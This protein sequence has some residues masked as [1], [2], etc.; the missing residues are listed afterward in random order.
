MKTLFKKMDEM[1]VGRNKVTYNRIM[2]TQ[3]TQEDKK[4]GI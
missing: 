2:A 3:R 4:I 1:M